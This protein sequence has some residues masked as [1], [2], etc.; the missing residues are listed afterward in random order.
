MPATAPPGNP[1]ATILA[2]VARSGV[3]P[4]SACAPPGETRN[5]V[6]TSSK[7]K[8]VS[9]DFVS[10]RKKLRK[11]G[12]TG[13]IPVEDPVGSRITAAMSS[14]E[15]AAVTPALSFGSTNMTFSAIPVMTP[16]VGVPSK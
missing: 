15:S 4:A 9:V 1:P 14:D 16:V 13:T 2:K 6:T 8:S 12:A 5:P 7:I 3:T 11:P 10:S